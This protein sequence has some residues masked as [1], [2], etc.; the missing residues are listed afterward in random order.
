MLYVVVV[1]AVLLYGLETWVI[2]LCIGSN[3]GGFHDRV[4]RRLTGKKLWRLLYGM[5]VYP[6]LL[7]AMMGEVLQE[8]DTYFPTSKTQLHSTLQPGTVWTFLWRQSNT[9]VK[10]WWEKEG[11]ELDGV[12]TAAWEA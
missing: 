12:Q 5:W 4:A 8:V 10:R 9:R 6:P 7:D 3:F 11:L 1:Q 2:S